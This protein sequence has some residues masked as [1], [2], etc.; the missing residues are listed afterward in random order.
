MAV[1]E[2][3]SFEIS[4]AIT[5]LLFIILLV[6]IIFFTLSYSFPISYNF[7]TIL[8]YSD[9]GAQL[10]ETSTVYSLGGA[11]FV[12]YWFAF[13]VTVFIITAASFGVIIILK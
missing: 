4:I 7:S 6:F 10:Y 9:F 11:L 5:T 3:T 13:I 8:K 2:Q 1:E 12:D